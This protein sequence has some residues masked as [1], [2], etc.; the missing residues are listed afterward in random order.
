MGIIEIYQKDP[1]ALGCSA[2]GHISHVLFERMSSRL[3]GWSEKG[4]RKNPK[5]TWH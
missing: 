4:V 5:V 3:L 2:E 1:D